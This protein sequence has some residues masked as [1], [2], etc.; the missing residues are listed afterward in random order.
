MGKAEELASAQSLA[1]TPSFSH[2]YLSFPFS[3]KF[4]EL[5][6]VPGSVLRAEAPRFRSH[7]VFS[8]LE[9]GV[10]GQLTKL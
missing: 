8:L 1:D 4:T 2:A 9:T 5:Y 7:R 6:D 3:Q 10:G